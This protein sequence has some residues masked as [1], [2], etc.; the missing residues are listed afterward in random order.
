M[1]TATSKK[2]QHSSI[3]N[4]INKYINKNLEDNFHKLEEQI[5]LPYTS[6]VAS[7]LLCL[8]LEF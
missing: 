7:A 8:A 4:E 3:K 2:F 6:K 5:L 1:T